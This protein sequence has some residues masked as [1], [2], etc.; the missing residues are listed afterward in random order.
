MEA[1]LR[2]YRSQHVARTRAIPDFVDIT[3]DVAGALEGSGISDGHVRVLAAEQGCSLL[4]QE[5]E[6]GL[7]FDIAEALRRLGRSG[8]HAPWGVIGSSSVVLP[9]VDGR[10]HLGTWQRVLLV[11]TRSPRP[12]T[13]FVHI[14]G[15]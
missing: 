12:R 2:D 7:L 5:R 8:G 15:R 4:V 1:T 11:E 14:V 6:S 10:L 9:A 13:V 3:G